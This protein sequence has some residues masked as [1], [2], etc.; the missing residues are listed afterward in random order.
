MALVTVLTPTYNRAARLGDLFRSL[1][2]QTLKDFE[3]LIVDDGSTDETEAVVQGFLKA[4]DFPVRYLHRENGGKHRALNTGIAQIS[5][6]LTFIVDSDDTLL[7]EGI[8][9]ISRF[10]EKYGD[11]PG[12]GVYSF[13]RTSPQKGILLQMPQ[14]ELIGSYVEERIR[15]SRPGDMAEVFFTEA[16]REF[17]FPAFPGERF[18]SEDVV[19]IPLG[20]KY[21]TV[22]INQAIY[23]CEYLEDGLTRNDKKHKFA[24]PLGSMLRGKRLMQRACGWKANIRGAIIYS[25]Y[26]REV[27]GP[28]PETVK[29]ETA[30]SRLL[31]AL[32]FPMGLVFN[33]KW[34]KQGNV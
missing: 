23:V 28:L 33:K 19:W 11:T 2:C 29:P 10:H 26:K 22:F 9:T 12:I 17:P 8:E 6:L 34:R 4:A 24:S 15:K 27:R 1:Q 32:M 14:E 20:L 7:P 18:L 31:V 21:R 16:L 13:L 5:T 25:C 30:G 3:W